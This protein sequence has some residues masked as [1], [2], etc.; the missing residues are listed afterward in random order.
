MRLSFAVFA[1]AIWSVA[2]SYKSVSIPETGID[3]DSAL[4]RKLLSQARRVAGNDD[5]NQQLD[6]T[7][8]SG[9]S[10]KFQGCHHIQQVSDFKAFKI[11]GT[12][13]QPSRLRADEW[14]LRWQS[15]RPDFYQTIGSLPSLS[16]SNL[17]KNKSRRMQ[18]W[19]R[20]L[21]CWP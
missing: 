7:W 17:L 8:V 18:D 15:G 2:A 10:L 21:H 13:P 9:Y 11:S 19:L 12:L 20:R 4:G 3:A 6:I 16:S 5:Q 1:T 14:K